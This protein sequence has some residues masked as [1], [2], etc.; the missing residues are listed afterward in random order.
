VSLDPRIRTAIAETTSNLSQDPTLG[1]KLIAWLE[2]LASQNASMD[3]TQSRL[4]YLD[5]LYQ[6]TR[7][8]MTPALDVE[9]ILA[10]DEDA[11]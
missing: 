11:Q 9:M 6:A 1:T 5:L 10:L 7:V 3:D 4:T 8:E 2:A